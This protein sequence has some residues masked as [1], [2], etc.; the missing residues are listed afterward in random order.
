MCFGDTLDVFGDTLDVFEDHVWADLKQLDMH[1]NDCIPLPCEQLAIF[2]TVAP[3]LLHVWLGRCKTRKIV[4]I[5]IMP[6]RCH[7]SVM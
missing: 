1:C 3:G 2:A 4:H 5:R 6:A 7:E